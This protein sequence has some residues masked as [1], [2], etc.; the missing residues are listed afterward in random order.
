MSLQQHTLNEILDK[1]RREKRIISLVSPGFSWLLPLPTSPRS[2]SCYLSSTATN[3]SNNGV[4]DTMQKQSLTLSPSLFLPPFF[5]NWASSLPV[6]RNPF[7]TSLVLLACSILHR[8]SG[9][10]E[11]RMQSRNW[12]VCQP[13]V[14]RQIVMPKFYKHSPLHSCT[15]SYWTFEPSTY[16]SF[17]PLLLICQSFLLSC[18]LTFLHLP[19]LLFI[20]SHPH[21]HLPPVCLFSS[22]QWDPGVVSVPS[23]QRVC[24]WGPV[25]SHPVWRGAVWQLQQ[26]RQTLVLLPT[27][28]PSMSELTMLFVF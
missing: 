21:T 28:P 19:S 15:V 7:L 14:G 6:A 1:Y 23:W 4:S 2:V 10:A 20:F 9:E 16:Q 27:L 12:D 26:P 13:V 8:I 11:Q 17:P 25:D 22:P 18:Y 3:L 5:F 24:H